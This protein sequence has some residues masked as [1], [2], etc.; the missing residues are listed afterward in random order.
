MVIVAVTALTADVRASILCVCVCA[1]LQLMLV[2]GH[3][4]TPT[5]ASKIKQKTITCAARALVRRMA[6]PAMYS[7]SHKNVETIKLARSKL[8]STSASERVCFSE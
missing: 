6:R 1:C 8:K 5:N 7:R 2:L 4:H 3:T